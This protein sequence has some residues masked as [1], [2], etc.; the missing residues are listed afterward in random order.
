[1]SANIPLPNGQIS[2]KKSYILIQ[3]YTI[4][5][6]PTEH[7]SGHLDL[8]NLERIQWSPQGLVKKRTTLIGPDGGIE[9]ISIG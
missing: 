9:V 5:N 6:I 7:R 8:A 1:L 3:G 2:F 4:N